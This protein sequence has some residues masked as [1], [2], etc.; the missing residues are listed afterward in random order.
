MKILLIEDEPDIAAVVKQGLEEAGYVVDAAGDGIKGLDLATSGSYALIL[1]D[2]MLPRMDG[3]RVCEELRARRDATPIL[4]LT[5]RDAVQDRVRGL[6][7]GADDYLPKPFDFDELLARVRALLRRDSV[8]KAR[9]IRVADLEID[10]GARRVTRAGREII[11]TPREYSLL[12]ALASR[13][14]RVLTRD[15]IRETVWADEDSYS[16]TVDVYIG[17]LRKKIDAGHDVKLIQT[18]HG[19]GYTLKVPKSGE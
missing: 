1:L 19:L 5:A 11:L 7:L 3:W 14:G 8:H 4:M 16:N 13:Q 12:V 2:L 18:V 10:T 17:L 9:V 6:D 15:V